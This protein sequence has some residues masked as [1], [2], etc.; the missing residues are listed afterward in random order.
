MGKTIIENVKAI[1]DANAMHQKFHV[2]NQKLIYDLEEFMKLCKDTGCGSLF[3]SIVKAQSCTWQSEERLKSTKICTVVII[4]GL[5]YGLSH[6]CNYF[7]KDFVTYLRLSGVS[8]QAIDTDRSVSDC[9][10]S[11]S[12]E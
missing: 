1:K 9:C 7:Q 5:C 6:W 3:D 2:E 4:Y 11:R 12:V 10:S 8:L